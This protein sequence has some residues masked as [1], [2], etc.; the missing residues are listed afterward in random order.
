M[1]TFIEPAREEMLDEFVSKK[2]DDDAHP[3]D[4]LYE[5]RMFGTCCAGASAR[6]SP[7]E[8]TAYFVYFA[9]LWMSSEGASEWIQSTLDLPPRL[10]MPPPGE[11]FDVN[12]KPESLDDAYVKA[13]MHCVED[14]FADS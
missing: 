11:D 4:F 5:P 1:E 2:E 14:D 3:S 12:A 10:D 9:S 7:G 6:G 13:Y 8:A